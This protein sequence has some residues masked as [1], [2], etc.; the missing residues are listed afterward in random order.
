MTGRP[1]CLFLK[2]ENTAEITPLQCLSL[3]FFRCFSQAPQAPSP[4][5][6]NIPAIV[7]GVIGGFVVNVTLLV[8]PMFFGISTVQRVP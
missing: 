6:L 5:S 4:G 7:G 2:V 3:L 8:V 1:Y